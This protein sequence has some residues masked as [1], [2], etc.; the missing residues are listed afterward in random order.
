M[1]KLF[2]VTRFYHYAEMYDVEAETEKEAIEK[3]EEGF[4]SGEFGEPD[5]IYQEFDFYE[6]QEMKK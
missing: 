6:A 3:L 1:K 2:V 4:L 5:D